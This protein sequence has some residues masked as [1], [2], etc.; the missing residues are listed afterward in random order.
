[1]NS[2][3]LSLRTAEGITFNLPL[4]GPVARFLAWCVDAVAAGLLTGLLGSVAGM[5]NVILP[6]LAEA[7]VVLAFFLIQTGYGIALEWFWRGQTPGKRLF[8]LRVMDAEGL[9]LQFGQVVMRNLLR[10]VDALPVLYM[11]GGAACALTRHAQRLGD[12]AANTVVIRTTRQYA[13]DYRQIAAGPFNSLRAHPHLAARLRQRV[14]PPEAMAA[15]QALLRRDTLEP[16]ARVALFAELA[17]HFR[18]L[19]PFPPEA[20]EGLTDEAYLR[21]VTDVLFRPREEAPR[22][23]SLRADRHEA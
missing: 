3:R 15:F 7:L 11:V 19:V 6:G 14:T 23:P 1:M 21:A 10:P 13:P 20:V 4:A 18:D 2:S 17:E 12:L 22:Q 9:R 5:V 8:G 16:A